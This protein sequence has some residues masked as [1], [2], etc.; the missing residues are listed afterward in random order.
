MNLGD[1]ILQAERTLDVGHSG[2]LM[3]RDWSLGFRAFVATLAGNQ[4]HRQSDPE[5]VFQDRGQGLGF[6]T[7][8]N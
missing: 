7:T 3:G 8:L 1:A 5:V 2:A 4:Y 6:P